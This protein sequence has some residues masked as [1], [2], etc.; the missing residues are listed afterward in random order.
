MAGIWV[1]VAE[2][3]RAKIYEAESPLGDLHE[4]EDLVHTEG[5]LHNSKVVS[6]IPGKTPSVAGTGTHGLQEQTTVKE[7]E[8]EVFAKAIS[9]KLESARVNG[10]M[11]RLVI[12]AAPHFLGLIR[13]NL[14]PNTAKLVSSEINKN[15]VAFSSKE[16]REHLP[17]PL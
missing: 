17:K 14:N 10:K 5:R 16:V 8:A 6:D 3:S 7:H 2:S 4:L 13:K 11:H 9:D 12:A 15:L 1:L